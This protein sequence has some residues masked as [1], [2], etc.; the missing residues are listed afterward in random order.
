MNLTDK[1]RLILITNDDGIEAPGIKKL[2]ETAAGY[3]QVY[4][5]APDGQRSAMSHSITCREAL[6]LRE[7]D[8]QI[9][10]VKAFAC[11]GTPADCVLVGIKKFFRGNRIMF[12]PVSIS[13]LIFPQIYSIPEQQVQHLKVRFSVSGLPHFQPELCHVRKC[14]T[15]ISQR[16]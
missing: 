11:S 2:A 3:G 7:Y 4:V 8:L 5:I 12:F 14:V 9:D 16:Q 10:G 15:D 1:E 6:R 13:A